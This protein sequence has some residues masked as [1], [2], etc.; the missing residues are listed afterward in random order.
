MCFFCLLERVFSAF[1]PYKVHSTGLGVY[2]HSCG[3]LSPRKPGK[4]E[5]KLLTFSPGYGWARETGAICQIGVLS[6]QLEC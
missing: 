4:R 2:E 6:E 3:A 5:G 1:G